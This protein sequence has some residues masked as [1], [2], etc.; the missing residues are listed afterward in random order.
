MSPG[1]SVGRTHKVRETT[2][3]RHGIARRRPPVSATTRYHRVFPCPAAGRAADGERAEATFCW[4]CDRH[5]VTKPGLL[6]NVSYR[7][8]R[9]PQWDDVAERFVNDNDANRY[10]NRRF[11]KDYKL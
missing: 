10:L 3:L 2:S 11:R 4:Q 9:R 5:R 1:V 7:T 8:G 6:A